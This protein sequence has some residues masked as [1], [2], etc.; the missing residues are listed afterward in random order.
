MLCIHLFWEFPDDLDSAS[1]DML[2][3]EIE[4]VGI[5]LAQGRTALNQPVVFLLFQ[6]LVQMTK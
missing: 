4:V 1:G 2:E 3:H 5:P 6:N